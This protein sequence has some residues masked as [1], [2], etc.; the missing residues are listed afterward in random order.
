MLSRA[1]DAAKIKTVPLHNMLHANVLRK[2]RLSAEA[3]YLDNASTR[4]PLDPE[5]VNGPVNSYFL[6]TPDYSDFVQVMSSL[7]DQHVDFLIEVAAPDFIGNAIGLGMVGV[8]MHSNM[9]LIDVP[10]GK[11]IWSG[12]M[13]TG[14]TYQLGGDLHN[15]ERD[16]LKVLKEA[17]ATG[18]A[19]SL[20]PKTLMRLFGA[21][22]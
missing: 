15:L 17:I 6:K 4:N 20:S 22:E 10:S 1:F 3:D 11:V 16:N 12:Y 19:D 7:Q 13:N 8:E 2:Y 21:E 14:K 9:R 18:I 5:L